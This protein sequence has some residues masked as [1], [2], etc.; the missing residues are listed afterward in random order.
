MDEMLG[1]LKEGAMKAKDGA[2]KFAKVAV[3]KTTDV[4]SQTKLN[5]AISEI[6]DKIKK[7]KIELG[8]SLYDEYKNGAAF[9]GE[10]LEHC[11]TIDKLNEEMDV[12]KEKIAELKNAVI[13]PSCG[14]YNGSGNVFCSKC[15]EKLKND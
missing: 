14:E 7:I 10:I 8:Q 2:E 5:Y 13:C 6:E 9:E 15:G 3:K 4:V 11:E 12:L 1:K